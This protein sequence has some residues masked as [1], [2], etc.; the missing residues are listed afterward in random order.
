VGLLVSAINSQSALI[1]CRLTYF[2][3]GTIAASFLYFFYSF[4]DDTHPPKHL[5]WSIL[6]LQSIFFFLFIFTDFVIADVF[7]LSSASAWGWTF[8]PLSLIFELSFFGFFGVGILMLYKKYRGAHDHML[9]KHL[10]HMFWVIIVGAIPPSMTAIILP[11]FGY[12]DLNW[13][14]PVSEIFWIP[15][16]A[17]SITKYRLFNAPA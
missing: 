7:P 12:F 3:G 16:I 5:G 9:R 2:L 11:R 15:I 4:P 13:V 1:L 10:K 17:Y 8:G 6:F 14:S